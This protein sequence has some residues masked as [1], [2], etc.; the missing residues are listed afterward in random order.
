MKDGE[1]VQIPG[2]AARFIALDVGTDTVVIAIETLPGMPFEP[3]ALE[4]MELIRSIA[5]EPA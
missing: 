2:Q 4:A 3:F 5:F 1:F